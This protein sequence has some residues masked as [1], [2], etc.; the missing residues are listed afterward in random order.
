[1]TPPALARILAF[2]ALLPVLCSTGP[3]GAWY[4]EGRRCAQTVWQCCCAQT[5]REQDRECAG[6]TSRR[7]VAPDCSGGCGCIMVIAEC[8]AHSA[9]V[10]P[11]KSLS[12]SFV[13]AVLPAPLLVYIAPVLAE[14]VS[15]SIEARGPPCVAVALATPS[16]RAP[17]AA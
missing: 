7:A 11:T 5:T 10:T 3:A 4:C 14:A 16:L 6:P 1:M 2:V 15:H 8:D 17:P 12:F 9:V 13:T